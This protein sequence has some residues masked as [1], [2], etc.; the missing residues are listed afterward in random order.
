MSAGTAAQNKYMILNSEGNELKVIEIEMLLH[1][2]Y[3]KVSLTPSFDRNCFMNCFEMKESTSFGLYMR[4]FL[5][6]EYIA[7]KGF[8]KKPPF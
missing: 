1:L 3:Y 7:H 5:S 8:A 2:E 4:K 6:S